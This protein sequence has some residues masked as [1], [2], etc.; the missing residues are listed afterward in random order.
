MCPSTLALRKPDTLLKLPRIPPEGVEE[1][2]ELRVQSHDL[3]EM[4]GRM[5]FVKGSEEKK[6][7]GVLKLG[8]SYFDTRATEAWQ[9]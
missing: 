5:G 3:G 8:V 9:E 7:G 2:A 1:G 6:K 4:G